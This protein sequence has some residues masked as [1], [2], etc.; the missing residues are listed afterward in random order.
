MSTIR[1]DDKQLLSEL[2]EIKEL[3][4]HPKLED[5]LRV[6]VDCYRPFMLKNSNE[7]LKD[8]AKKLVARG[9]L[10]KA[11]EAQV[12]EFALKLLILTMMSKPI[13]KVV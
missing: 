10:P 9:Y 12:V 6:L 7:A 1:V 2:H 8:I 5:T 3:R 11:T 13:K 4:G